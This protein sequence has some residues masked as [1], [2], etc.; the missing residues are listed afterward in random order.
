MLPR[1]IRAILRPMAS[2]LPARNRDFGLLWIAQIGSQGPTRMYQI[3]LAWWILQNV[4][5]NGGIAM[6]GMMI[7]SAL[8]P[9]LFVKPFGRLI[10]R[11][12]TQRVLILTDALAGVAA[13]A[14]WALWI[15]PSIRLIGVY[16][17][18]FALASAQTVIDA[19]LSKA[20][21]EIVDPDD[22]PSGVAFQS[23]T[24]S[25]AALFGAAL[26]AALIDVLGVRGVIALNALSYFVSSGVDALIRFRF[27]TPPAESAASEAAGWSVLD[28]MPELRRLLVGFGAVNFFAAP[29]FVILPLYTQRV[30]NGSASLLATF[31]ATLAGAILAGTLATPLFSRFNNA[32]RLA[33][34]AIMTFG[35]AAV[36]PGMFT[37]AFTYTIALIVMG[38]SVGIVNV[39]FVAHFQ[40][41]VPADIKGRFFTLLQAICGF[42]FPAAFFLFGLLGDWTV[43]PTLC[44]IQGLGV[45][46]V[47]AWF[48]IQSD[49]G[50]PIE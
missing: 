4:G 25:I 15:F 24:Q 2:A 1:A 37:N 36:L 16:A 23:S 40:A 34:H 42:S 19:A 13:L 47:G 5:A 10:D 33:A 12:N 32:I 45:F 41:I 28:P 17:I 44:L 18:A 11:T 38:L 7:L 27:P 50:L 3:A 39:R 21:P 48:W 22:I 29:L 31:E 20:V 14:L 26:G 6:A 43:V 30:L 8:P 9:I 35:I 46:T 49:A